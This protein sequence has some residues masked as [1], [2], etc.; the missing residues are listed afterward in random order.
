LIKYQI[1]TNNL[2]VKTA[3]EGKCKLT[4]KEIPCMELFLIVRDMVQRGYKL[5]TDIM[6]GC[7]RPNQMFCRTVLMSL[8][9]D[10][11]VDSESERIINSSL[12]TCKR[13]FPLKVYWPSRFTVDF[14]EM[15]Y[16][17]ISFILDCLEESNRRR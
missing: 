13:F 12:K 4:Y 1:L 10:S 16:A 5:L 8:K 17:M 14:Q 3:Y 6:G 9:P 2:M 15:D 11:K 7:M